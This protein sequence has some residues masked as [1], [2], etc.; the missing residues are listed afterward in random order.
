MP[1]A[2]LTEIGERGISLSGGQQARLNIARCVYSRPDVMLLDDPL[3]A[4]DQRVGGFVF[5]KAFVELLD[6]T[7]VLVLNQ[8]LFM[9][10]F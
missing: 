2:D 4:L 10:C 6:C 3:A 8:V 1:F 9:C 7:V 5:Q